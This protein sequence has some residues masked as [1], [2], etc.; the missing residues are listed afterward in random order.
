[1][2]PVITINYTINYTDRCTKGYN[3]KQ[4]GTR[5]ITNLFI[6][7]NIMNNLKHYETAKK[8]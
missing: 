1:M 5:K 6:I 2:I 3:V 7:K 4:A 8:H